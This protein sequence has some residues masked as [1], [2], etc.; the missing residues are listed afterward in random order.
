MEIKHEYNGISRAAFSTS[1]SEIQ[2][3]NLYISFA[4]ATGPL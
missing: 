2:T 1:K 4:E 3:F